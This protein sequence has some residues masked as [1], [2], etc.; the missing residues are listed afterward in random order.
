[1]KRK[2]ISI[3][4]LVM[5][6]SSCATGNITTSWP[7][8]YFFKAGMKVDKEHR[9]IAPIK[10]STIR[11]GL[12]GESV[13]ATAIRKLEEQAHGYGADAV[14]DVTS[15]GS[16][17]Y[18]WWWLLTVF[19]TPDCAGHASGVM[20]KWVD[21][22]PKPTSFLFDPEGKPIELHRSALR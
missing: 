7:K 12:D 11:W 14:V 1:M 3:I 20:V 4:S 8:E 16:C 5:F 13:E 22:S 18:A 2:I 17:I 19:L 9:T 15:D 21:S 10:T 6:L